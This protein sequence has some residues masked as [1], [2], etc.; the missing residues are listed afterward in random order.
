VTTPVIVGSVIAV[1]GVVATLWSALPPERCLLVAGLI[2]AS[3]ATLVASWPSDDALEAQHS[4]VAGYCDDVAVSLSSLQV[5]LRTEPR[6][7]SGVAP[8]AEARWRDAMQ[9]LAT[10]ATALCVPA[11]VTCQPY[12]EI[13]VGTSNEFMHALDVLRTALEKQRS[14]SRRKAP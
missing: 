6:L 10:H 2:V 3:A 13:P 14:C 8:V 11:P 9:G 4:I 12:L 1:V 7:A 5:E